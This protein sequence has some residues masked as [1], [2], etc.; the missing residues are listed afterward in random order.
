M[1]HSFTLG[2]L[3]TWSSEGVAFVTSCFYTPCKKEI[4]SN[5]ETHIFIS[6]CQ[7]IT[8]PFP[9]H[10]FSCPDF[11]KTFP[12]NRNSSILVNFTHYW[13]MTVTLPIS[14][15]LILGSSQPLSHKS[16]NVVE[17]T[18]LIYSPQFQQQNSKKNIRKTKCH[19]I[20]S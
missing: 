12:S 7:T 17:S 16:G 18:P 2:Y 10:N 3:L 9:G 4:L 14:P 1:L 6:H 15:Y 20:Q 19:L 5:T 8:W 13:W 11:L